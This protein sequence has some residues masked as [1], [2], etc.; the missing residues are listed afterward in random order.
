VYF[1]TAESEGPV[2]H[3]TQKPVALG[4]YLIRTYTEPG[5]VVLDNACGSGSFLVAAVEEGRRALG[6]E[7]NE[8]VTSFRRA[9][10]DMI[11]VV[12]SRLDCIGCSP[13]IV[14]RHDSIQLKR[15]IERFFS[16]DVLK[17]W[18]A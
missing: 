10:I 3:S 2:Y 5:D 4:R 12:E 18:A 13:A 11:S 6:I 14:R 1:K 9:P 7:I 16:T 17:K 8:E 15:S